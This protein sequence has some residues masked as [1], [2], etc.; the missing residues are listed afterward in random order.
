M[1]THIRTLL[2][3][4]GITKRNVSIP[5]VGVCKINGNARVSP[6]I[7]PAN[8]TFRLINIQTSGKKF[9][10]RF[11]LHAFSLSQHPT[12]MRLF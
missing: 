9:M 2:N 6:L 1:Y 10:C 8:Q 11:S 12:L 5:L 3:S 4:S 7:N